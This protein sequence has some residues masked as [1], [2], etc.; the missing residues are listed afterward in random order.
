MNHDNFNFEQVMMLA[1]FKATSEQAQHFTGKFKYKKKQDFQ[2]RESYGRKILE[3]FERSNPELYL[4]VEEVA[5]GFHDTIK[6]VR[7]KRNGL[8]K[9]K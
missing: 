4:R 9:S 3:D 1:L 6:E 2:M 8:D 7:R 5:D